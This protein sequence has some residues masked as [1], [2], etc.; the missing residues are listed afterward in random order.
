MPSNLE[1]DE[2]KNLNSN[3]KLVMSR[4]GYGL[5]QVAYQVL[6]SGKERQI[7]FKKV[8]LPECE[9]KVRMGI[10]GEPKLR[11]HTYEEVLGNPVFLVPGDVYVAK[12]SSF[13]ECT[14]TL[15][16]SVCLSFVGHLYDNT[17]RI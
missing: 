14:L 7:N 6:G 5:V 16:F 8:V 15:F 9:M 3:R 10:A 1:Q 2:F 17:P 12:N 13:L 4:S 11:H